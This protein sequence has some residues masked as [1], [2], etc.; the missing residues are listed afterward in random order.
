MSLFQPRRPL[1][2]ALR[3]VLRK[4]EADPGPDTENITELKR[5]LR[6]RIV[7]YEATMGL[8]NQS[9]ALGK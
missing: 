1:I 8:A 9:S 5:I 7:R 2:D 6:E 3:D 4:M